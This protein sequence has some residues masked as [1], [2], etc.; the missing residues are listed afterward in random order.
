V[1]SSL[2]SDESAKQYLQSIKDDYEKTR[3]LHASRKATPLITFDTAN[4]NAEKLDWDNFAIPS[5]KFIG[6]RVFKNF[7]LSEIAKFIDWTPFFQTW[8]LAGKFP[9]IL[10]DEIVGESATKVFADGQKMLERLVQGRWLT[11]NAVV[12]FYPAGSVGEDI[13][14]FKD[15]SRTEKILTWHQLRQQTDRPV[16][17]GIK[18]PNRCLADYVAPIDSGKKDYVGMFAVTTGHGVDAK[19]DEFIREHDDYNAILLKALADRLAEAFAEY[20]HYRVRTDLWGYAANESLSNDEMIDEKYQGIRPAPGYPACPE[21]SVK[22]GMFE[23]LQADEIGMELTES[24]AMNPASSVS[25]FYLAN[26]SAQ[27][28]NVGQIGLDQVNDLADRSARNVEDTIRAV[29]SN[30]DS[31]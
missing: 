20:M 4:Q 3:Q 27:Y 18:R 30:F 13:V 12:G 31:N 8:D 17:D 29:S 2:L 25:G 19:V 7:D 10:D 28:F 21:H 26:P 15:E 23:V 5:P 24:L 9:K 14:L 1:A 6:R 22:L 11:A 16:V